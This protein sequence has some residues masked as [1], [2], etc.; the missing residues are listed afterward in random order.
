MGS[1]DTRG[2]GLAELGLGRPVIQQE[3]MLMPG[4]FVGG[5][6]T[7]GHGDMGGS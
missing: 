2:R 6:C 5:G 3:E 4:F 7:M 1:T